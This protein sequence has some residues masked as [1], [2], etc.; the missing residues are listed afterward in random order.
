MFDVMVVMKVESVVISE[1][2]VHTCVKT[3]ILPEGYEEN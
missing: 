1:K 2:E 3:N